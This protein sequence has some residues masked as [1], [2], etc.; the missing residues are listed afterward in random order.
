MERRNAGRRRG[1]HLL[2]VQ[3]LTTGLTWPVL[4]VF[5]FRL[6]PPGIAVRLGYETALAAD[7]GYG[8]SPDALLPA[9]R[10]LDGL[11]T[12]AWVAFAL[13]LLTLL[14]GCFTVGLLVYRDGSR[15]REEMGIRAAVGASRADLRRFVMGPLTRR[16]RLGTVAGAVLGLGLLWLLRMTAPPEIIL[17]RLWL[18][19]LS[20]AAV[21]GPVLAARV[22][23]TLELRVA[24]GRFTRP[25][26]LPSVAPLRPMGF[27][28]VYFGV[29]IA[30]LS[31]ASVLANGSVTS[32]QDVRE[33]TEARDTLLFE[34][35]SPEPA[36]SLAELDALRA[37]DP[38]RTWNLVS[39]GALEGLG[40]TEPTLAECNCVLGT[41]VSPYRLMLTQR[42]SI[43]PGTFKALGIPIVRGRAFT[44]DDVAGAEGVAVIDRVLVRRF[45]GV[46]P[47][48]K[49]V[50]IFGTYPAS[51]WY[52]IVGV[53]DV[54]PP[55][56]LATTNRPIGGL[57]LSALQH[58]PTHGQLVVRPASATAS[59]DQTAALAVIE[60]TA[61]DLET[62][63]LGLLSTRL[64]QSAAVLSWFAILIACVTIAAFVL[65][66][67]GVSALMWLDVRARTPEFGV[68]RAVGACRRQV[69]AQVVCEVA[70]VVAVGGAFGSI[71]AVG[72]TVGLAD[73]FTAVDTLD[74]R[75]LIGVGVILAMAAAVAAIHPTRRALAIEPIGAIGDTR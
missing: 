24:L 20:L 7:L 32:D 48:G 59:I 70:G 61:P 5:S 3:V 22:G 52:R 27:G 16:L 66:I 26:T 57:Y 13:A 21:A 64:R 18:S 19:V 72:F 67:Y 38:A 56:D 1:F 43:S 29:L 50:R 6:A 4:S 53:A 35:E 54:P 58:P 73:R 40:V 28:G 36:A 44:E 51:T 14:V 55:L 74:G 39:A 8:F 10:Q 11:S 75:M 15:C 65:G 69:R 47:I 63:P 41:I 23:A 37:E 30:V 25:L 2:F 9:T 46:D 45:G 42:H 60:R 12:L 31:T 62:R 71:L 33:W 17:P 34:I 49:Q 68:R